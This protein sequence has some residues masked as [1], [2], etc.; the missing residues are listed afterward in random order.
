ME[1]LLIVLVIG[2]ALA[3]VVQVGRGIWLRART[4]ERHQQALDT[5]AGLTQR[6]DGQRP[7]AQGPEELPDDTFDG[8]FEHQAHVRLIMPGGQTAGGDARA[9]P[10]PRTAP[11]N[12]ST[13]RRPSRTTPSSAGL[14]PMTAE[15]PAAEPPAAEP[16]A[17]EAP[18]YEPAAYETVSIDAAVTA[19]PLTGPETGPV[20]PVGL[21]PPPVPAPPVLARPVLAPPV[22]GSPVPP[23]TR[24]ET[25][26]GLPPPPT[27]SPATS[28]QPSPP[29]V[30][31]EP[32]TVPVPIVQP[33]V[34]YFDDLSSRSEAGDGSVQKPR[35][36]GRRRR[37]SEV[38]AEHLMPGLP[39]PPPFDVSHKPSPGGEGKPGG[40]KSAVGLVLAAAAIC[41]ALAAIGVTLLGLPGQGTPAAHNAAK[42]GP[43]TSAHRTTTT[44]PPPKSPPTTAPVAKPAVL[45]SSQNGTATYELRSASASIVVS[46]SGAC[47]LEVR[48]NSPLG[49]IVYEGTL[50]AGVHFSVTGPA[51]I[52]LGNPP[53]VAVKVNGTPMTVPGSQLAVPVNLQFTFG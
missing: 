22:L 24:Q 18:A 42:S 39:P 35:R 15:P 26:P 11:S 28:V 17:Y 2:C 30:F 34:F 8:A 1:T 45:V 36:L 20:M 47:W 32:P 5:L 50:E 29:G 40:R 33:Q 7:E 19:A 13:F 27:Y 4:V 38:T 16:P 52:R 10:P 12:V 25:I 44:S 46:A 49:Q 48:A 6:P 51:W 53:A 21:P 3:F 23:G 9:L 31:V 43:P 37:R 41:V 14:E